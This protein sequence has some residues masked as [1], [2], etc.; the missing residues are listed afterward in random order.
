M[1][2]LLRL[3]GFRILFYSR[4]RSEPPHV[5]VERGDNHAKVWLNPPRLAKDGGFTDREI[6]QIMRVVREREVNFLEAWHAY[7]GTVD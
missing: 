4:D 7:F 5:H 1:P 6:R 2:V 3:Q